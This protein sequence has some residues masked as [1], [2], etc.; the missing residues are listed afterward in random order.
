M[1][2]QQDPDAQRRVQRLVW[3]LCV[4]WA[5]L[6]VSAKVY[7]A[8]QHVGVAAAV[9]RL[10]AVT[11]TG[12][13][14]GA[15]AGVLLYGPVRRA[16]RL[17]WRHGLVRG[18]ILGG[19]S[20]LLFAPTGLPPSAHQWGILES[21]VLGSVVGAVGGTVSA[22]LG[23]AERAFARAV[24]RLNRGDRDGACQALRE[25][26]ARASSDRFRAAR[27]PVA[28]AFLEGRRETLDVS[29]E[30][31]AASSPAGRGTEPEAAGPPE[32]PPAEEP[33][34]PPERQRG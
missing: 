18:A 3:I 7:A 29:F 23:E 31:E 12:S 32:V 26:L 9:L 14:V 15:A 21:V 33:P 8:A 10:L 19:L 27:V 4:L 34:R 20:S 24:W 11:V 1:R 30:L 28:E 13:V 5:V 2:W 6:L 17:P 16:L 22:F 25:Y